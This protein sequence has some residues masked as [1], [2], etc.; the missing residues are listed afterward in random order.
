MD[1][2]WA[3]GVYNRLTWHIRNQ[4]RVVEYE[5]LNIYLDRNELSL[6]PDLLKRFDDL[7]PYDLDLQFEAEL[8]CLD[9]SDMPLPDNT[10]FDG[11]CRYR[12]D[13]TIKDAY[14]FFCAWVVGCHIM[15]K[16]FDVEII[17]NLTEMSMSNILMLK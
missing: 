4:I 1:S 7:T 6:H 15:S 8:Q 16:Y 14:F 11:N 3:A 9:Q 17:S 10:Y 12:F 2:S 13:K 5:G